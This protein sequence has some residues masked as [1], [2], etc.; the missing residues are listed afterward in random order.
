MSLNA[1]KVQNVYKHNGVKTKARARQKHRIV[2]WR[3]LELPFTSHD[4]I[5][6]VG[7]QPPQNG[8]LA[9]SK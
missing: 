1:L 3:Q 5:V 6:A 4:T 7:T 9:V 2:F 8:L